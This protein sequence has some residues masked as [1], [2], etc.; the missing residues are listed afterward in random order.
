MKDRVIIRLTA[1]SVLALLGLAACGTPSPQPDGNNSAPVVRDP[2]LL[3]AQ[4]LSAWRVD[5]DAQRAL[6]SIARA[7]EVA[8]DRPDLMWL[9]MRLCNE[10]RGC[11]PEPIEAR[12]RKA[13]S[14]NGSAWLGVL[15]R[16]QMRR[17]ARA[18]E[19]IVEAMSR[20]E[21]FDVRWTSLVWRLTEAIR[22]TAGSNEHPISTALDQ[23]TELLSAAAVPA[24][25]PL[26][27]ACSPQSTRES[28]RAI[29]C[30]RIAQALQNSDTTLAEGIGLGIAQ[31]V[32]APGSSAAAALEARVAT[33]TYRSQ[34]AGSLI[35]SQ[36]EREKFSIEMLE[37]LKKLPREQDVSLA[38]LRWAGQPL[39]P[40]PAGP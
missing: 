27:A 34:V 13:D 35:R 36:V 1:L 38:I 4:A 24:F 2:D 39:T 14:R 25:A 3:A 5:G 21:N 18:E 20:A 22:S 31:R 16:A 15:A 26:S 8:P 10:S 28:N 32:A 40:Q 9:H 7:T 17:D 23:A 12:F 6:A 37:L 11:E 29:H 30:E 33:L 19:Q